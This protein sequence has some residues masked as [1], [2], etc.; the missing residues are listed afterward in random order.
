LRYSD[1]RESPFA[2]QSKRHGNDYATAVLFD[3]QSNVIAA[4][5]P[6]SARW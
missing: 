3:A 5:K 6:S 2:R 4:G 1:S